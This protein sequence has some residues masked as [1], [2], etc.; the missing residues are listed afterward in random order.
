MNVSLSHQLEQWIQ[1]RVNSGLYQTASEVI[2]EALRLLREKEQLRELRTEELRKRIA[3]GVEDLEQG[4]SR[5]FDED[6]VMEIKTRGR[7]RA[8]RHGEP[9]VTS[10]RRAPGSQ[11]TSRLPL[12]R[13][14]HSR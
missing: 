13:S 11:V 2:R 5:E 10:Q 14:S 8:G 3:R 1:E 9:M 7:Q 4:R 6:L 12:P